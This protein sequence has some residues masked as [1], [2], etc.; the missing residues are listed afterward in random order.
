MGKEGKDISGSSGTGGKLDA[1]VPTLT[2]GDAYELRA[3]SARVAT[4]DNVRWL[5]PLRLSL[6]A[7]FRCD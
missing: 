2:A 6:L 3:P 4:Q 1:R 7:F 5:Q